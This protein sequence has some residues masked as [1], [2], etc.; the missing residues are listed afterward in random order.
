MPKPPEGAS[1]P[2]LWG[3]EDHVR[4]LFAETGVEFAFERRHTE[5]THGSAAGFVDYMAYHYG[6]LVKARERTSQDGTWDELRHDLVALC[7]RHNI[8]TDGFFARAE[9]LLARGVKT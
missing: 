1:P 5:V 9:Y 2:P 6:P 7:E 3:D 4:D 8:A